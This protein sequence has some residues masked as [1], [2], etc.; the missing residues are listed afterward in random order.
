MENKIQKIL[1]HH[2][3]DIIVITDKN[4]LIVWVNDWFTALTEYSFEEVY[5][6]KPGAL[7]QGKETDA[8]TIE[9]MSNAI[10][11]REKFNVNIV[12]YSKS[13]VKYWLNINC[14]PVF[15][16]D[17]EIEYFVAIERDITSEYEKNQYKLNK[18]IEEQERLSA[19]KSELI[20]LI[21]VLTHDLKSPL[22]NIQGLTDVIRT[23]D[24]DIK[25]MLSNEVSRSIALIN[26]ILANRNEETSKI[27]IA[28]SD[29]NPVEVIKKLE[30]TNKAKLALNSLN[31]RLVNSEDIFIKSDRILMDQILEN[32]FINAIKYAKEFSEIIFDCSERKNDYEI[33]ISN[34]TDMLEDWQLDKL[35]KP[36]QNFDLQFSE[37]SNGMGLYIVKKYIDLLEGKINVSKTKQRVYFKITIPKQLQL[38]PE[39]K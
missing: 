36:F 26:K 2:V 17:G 18:L 31:V 11:C 33:V 14:L 5:G 4:G 10:A 19:E 12:N 7:L 27:K 32:I 39:F 23:K 22:H 8:H 1:K 20:E 25:E 35:F 24:D 29:F 34:E 30:K 6:K 3:E 38:K 15:D 28:I 9:I 13:K 37:Q 16:S 21:Y